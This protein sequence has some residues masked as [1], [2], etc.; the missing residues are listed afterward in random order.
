MTFCKAPFCVN[1]VDEVKLFC[2]QCWQRVPGW[3]KDEIVDAVTDG[4]VDL[5]AL[6]LREAERRL[7][8]AARLASLRAG[9][10]GQ[11]EEI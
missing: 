7:G 11:P 4:D 9:L 10:V 1:Q 5:V 8:L 2:A 6:L 3:L